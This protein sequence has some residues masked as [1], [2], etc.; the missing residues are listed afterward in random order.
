MIG[1]DDDRLRIMHGGP[2]SDL[3]GRL[4]LK[5]RGRRALVFAM[6]C[7]VAPL[8]LLL[9]NHGSSGAA[10]FLRDC[11]AWAKF[12]I[13]P[14]LLTLAERP[15][16]FAID[17]CLSILL[18][19]PIVTSTSL[20]DIRKA[21]EAARERT[22]SGT[23][24][25]LCVVLAVTATVVNA[26]TFVEGVAPAWAMFDGDLSASGAWSLIVGN[27]VFWFLL[28]RL[29]WKHVVWWRF[30]QSLGRCRLRLAVTHPDG[31]AGLGFL[32][33]YPAG[34]GL[35]T[36]AASSVLAAGVGHVMQRQEVTPALFTTV[37]VIWLVVVTFYFAI[38]LNG[39]GLQISRL[40]RDTILLS[41]TKAADFERWNERK[42]LGR[43]VFEDNEEN[44]PPENFNDVKPFYGASLRTS[45]FLLN[46]KSILPILFPAL[47]PLLVAGT[48]FLPYSELGP[49]VKR[50]L[51]L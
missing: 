43:N 31:H 1:A 7:W 33:L 11:G 23:A 29:V 35:F 45:P 13:A 17:E 6:V 4:G 51:L 28:S 48:A 36:L 27:T 41:L 49:I 46:K 12:L 38:P 26:T 9:I 39:V 8:L 42:L 47:L 22:T 16:S 3:M 30:L 37:C 5:K 44:A 50:L 32:G 40:K 18:R 2:F 25:L 15:I 21:L 19:V 14:S 34:Y 24:E 20:P 10:I